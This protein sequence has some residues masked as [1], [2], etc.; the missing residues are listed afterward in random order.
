MTSPETTRSPLHWNHSKPSRPRPQ[1]NLNAD[2]TMRPTRDAGSRSDSQTW[3][4]TSGRNGSDRCS[5]S[6]DLV[7]GDKLSQ[8]GLARASSGELHV[9]LSPKRINPFEQSHS[10]LIFAFHC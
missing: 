10:L 4:M 5:P 6:L 7:A 3:L 2:G 1:A 9:D 8:Q